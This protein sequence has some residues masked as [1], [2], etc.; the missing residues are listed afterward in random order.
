MQDFST[1]QIALFVIGLLLGTALI[2]AGIFATIDSLWST[3]TTPWLKPA[4]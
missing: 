2:I 3:A 1:R 4:G